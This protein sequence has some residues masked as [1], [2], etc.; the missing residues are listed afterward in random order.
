M[1][2]VHQNIFAKISLTVMH[3]TIKFRI[4]KLRKNVNRGHGKKPCAALRNT[5]QSLLIQYSHGWS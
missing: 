4:D 3:I 2:N 1:F 5:A